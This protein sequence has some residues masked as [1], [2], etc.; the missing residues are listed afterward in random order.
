[1]NLLRAEL[2]RFRSRRSI[3][4][5]LLAGIIVALAVTITT[6]LDTRSSSDADIAKAEKQAAGEIK[7]CEKH[8]GRH[9]VKNPTDCSSQI[10][11]Y[12]LART[13]LDPGKVRDSAVVLATTLMLAGLLAATSFIGAE[14][15]SG[16]MSNLLLFEPRRWKVWAAKLIAAA[17]ALAVWGAVCMAIMLTV[18]VTLGRARDPGSWDGGWLQDTISTGG[19]AA[20]LVAVAALL[21]A[22]VTLVTRSTMG[23]AGLVFGY[24]LAGEGILRLIWDGPA[25]NL[26]VSN[27]AFGLLTGHQEVRVWPDDGGKP[28]LYVFSTDDSALYLGIGLVI[29]LVISYVAYARR[30]VD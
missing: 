3:V 5:L 21:G 15:S 13:K 2:I 24:I 4:L 8:P 1:M 9:R 16:S 17:L 27:R 10:R 22:A 20:V 19:R 29:V 11:D 12:Y 7:S 25:E 18:L 6:A 30:D 23:T 28:D 26:V 14:Y